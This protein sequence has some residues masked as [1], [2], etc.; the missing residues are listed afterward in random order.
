MRTKFLH[1]LSLLMILQTG[2]SQTMKSEATSYR[3]SMHLGLAAFEDDED[4]ER[5]SIRGF[6][7]GLNVGVY[8]ASKKTANFYNGGCYDNDFI[9]PSEVRCY[10]IEERLGVSGNANFNQTYNEVLQAVG[11]GATGFSV[12]RDAYPINMRYNPAFLLGLHMKY[13]FNRYSAIIFN[14]N[15]VKLKTTDRFTL[16]FFG[17]PIPVN[18]QA[19]VRLFTIV[20]NEQRF[21]I[22]LGYRQGWMMGDRSNFYLQAGASMLGSQFEQNQIIMNESLRYDLFIGIQNQQIVQQVQQRTDI[23]FGGYAS[24]GFE[25]WFK[26]R[27]TMDLSWGLSR[28][29]VILYSLD[30][31]VFN[32]M[33][34]ATFTI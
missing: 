5:D 12:P 27:Y 26:G 29:R 19:D 9:D 11:N 10:S 30:K 22:N 7:F 16:Q 25:F 34:Q 24:M 28:D 17:G 4:Y 18:A 31:K 15:T 2:S 20:G 33:L 6:S 14:L 1:L 23:G 3:A 32:N 13:N 21:N 8:F